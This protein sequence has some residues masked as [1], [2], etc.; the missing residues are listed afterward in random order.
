MSIKY[1]YCILAAGIGSRNTAISGMHKGL[2]PI[3]NIAILSH[4]ISKLNKEIE[5]VIA[6][7]YQSEQVIGYLKF[8]YPDR[9][10]TFIHIDKF[11]GSG[12]GPGYSLLQCKEHLQCPFVL[13]PSDIF[14]EQKDEIPEPTN[15]WIGGAKVS[16]SDSSKYCLIAGKDDL[17]QIYYG[18]GNKAY[19]GI[20]GIY[21]YQ[22][23]WSLLED[24]GNI[25][26]SEYQ[27]TFPFNKMLDVKVINYDKFNDTGSLESYLKIR[28]SVGEEIV[29]P[30]ND[31][32][33]YI[34]HGK[35]IKYFS[36]TKKCLNRIE[37]INYLG[38]I[39]PDTT[40]ISNNMFGYE[41]IA[42]KMLSEIYNEKI[43]KNF[44]T[45]YKSNFKIKE[46]NNQELFNNDC[47]LMHKQKTYQRISTLENLEIDKLK[48][49]NGI[50]V[51]TIRDLLNLIPWDDIIL[52]SIPA[53]FHGDLQPENILVDSNGNFKLIDWR[54]S[55][56][57]SLDIGD[58]YYDL[59]KLYHGLL[60]NGTLFKNDNFAVIK[61]DD[62]VE[63]QFL[64]KNNL[65][66]LM[67]MFKCFCDENGFNWNIV[68][69]LGALQYIN[70]SVF[71]NKTNKSY[72]EFIFLFGKLLLTK[73]LT[74]MEIK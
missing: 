54:E 46:L 34:D 66:E 23:F 9:Q 64:I 10:F 37:R 7:G 40:K 41:L 60:I 47:D 5:I 3:K 58:A 53:I 32:A 12:T 13:L 36:N 25:H 29:F 6:V 51:I 26:N 31:E 8:I 20:A 56:G 15:N 57:D 28:D 43:L 42:G 18:L 55:F 1:K 62:S 39:I 67:L 65:N 4:L 17:I 22:L 49:I 68:K 70:I 50:D 11:S 44:F 33:I 45:F 21:D 27:V 73:Y 14:L 19:N 38:S 52:K 63:L 61:T 30:K 35:V 74:E 69:L 72:S 24:N 16:K 71:Y 59:G 48:I 2:L